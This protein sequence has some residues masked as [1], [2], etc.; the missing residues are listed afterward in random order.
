MYKMEL[1]I[2][3][4]GDKLCQNISES[5]TVT[6]GNSP[7][8]G[9][10]LVLNVGAPLMVDTADIAANNILFKLILEQNVSRKQH[11]NTY[12]DLAKAWLSYMVIHRI[13]RLSIV[14]DH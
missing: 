10:F 9:F 11:F 4:H 5:Q 2:I 1:G 13:H 12:T 8:S 7:R 3:P 14:W 6:H